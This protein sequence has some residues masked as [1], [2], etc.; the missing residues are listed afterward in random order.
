MRNGSA[1]ACPLLNGASRT[2]AVRSGRDPIRSSATFTDALHRLADV[3]CQVPV[4]HVA[5]DTNVHV[6]APVWGQLRQRSDG[7]LPCSAARPESCLEDSFF[8]VARSPRESRGTLSPDK[9]LC[10]CKPRLE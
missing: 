6:S 8:A 2:V 7:V 4:S 5:M 10:G 3:V 9:R 1:D